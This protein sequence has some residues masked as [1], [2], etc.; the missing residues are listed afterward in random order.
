MDKITK[1]PW[2]LR[3]NNHQLISGNKHVAE[4]EMI[5]NADAEYICRAVNSHEGLVN[6]L[7]KGRLL[8]KEAGGFIRCHELALSGDGGN[9]NMAVMEIRIKEFEEALKKA[10]DGE[11]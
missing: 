9:S 1:L 5:S 8:A 6:A 3:D 2:K 4:L 7:E 11:V 10:A